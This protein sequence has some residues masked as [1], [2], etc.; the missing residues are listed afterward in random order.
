MMPL[1]RGGR[2]TER[3]LEALCVSSY[4]DAGAAT[5]IVHD[6]GRCLSAVC[7]REIA[8]SHGIDATS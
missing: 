3:D 6:G 2:Q 4:V 1:A 7:A 8:V 5:T